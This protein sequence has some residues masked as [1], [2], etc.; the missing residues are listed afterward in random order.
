MEEN[1]EWLWAAFSIAWILHILYVLTLA[2]RQKRLRQQVREL[3]AQ[4]EQFEER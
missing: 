3:K 1:L 2:A 4:L